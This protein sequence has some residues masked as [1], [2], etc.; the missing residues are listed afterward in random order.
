MA[1][2]RAVAELDQEY[3]H[4][5]H[6]DHPNIVRMV[7]F[8]QDGL[9]AY[10]FLE[11]CANG[12]LEALIHGDSATEMKEPRIRSYTKQILTG[13]K[14]LHAHN[15]LHRDIKPGNILVDSNGTLKL[16]D[17]GLS[18][19]ETSMTNTQHIAGTRHY[20][21]PEAFNG[22]FSAGSDIWAVGC[23]VVEMATRARPWSHLDRNLQAHGPLEFHIGNNQG[24]PFH[25]PRIPNNLS[26]E[27]KSFLTQCFNGNASHRGTCASLLES[28][29]FMVEAS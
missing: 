2:A 9:C 18:R 5:R 24:R 4:V 14:V 29:W 28:P 21:A 7:D 3:N 15:L 13:L 11:W 10:L 16:T 27:C 1:S 22:H 25:H 19:H 23:T 8:K 6:I 26:E 17:F 20:I 12:S